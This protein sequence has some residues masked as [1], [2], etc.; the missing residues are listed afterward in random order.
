MLL[1]FLIPLAYGESPLFVQDRS[2][3]NGVKFKI[4]KITS[5]LS[6][7]KRSSLLLFIRNTRI[8]ELPQLVNILKGNM[9]FVGPRPLLPEYD[10]VIRILYPDRFKVLPGLTGLA[11]IKGANKL[12][13]N[14]RLE[15]DIEYAKQQS[16][17]KD[18]LI[19]LKTPFAILYHW[20]NAN[21]VSLLDDPE[22]NQ[23]LRNEQPN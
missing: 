15:L 2:G 20:G 1:A 6:T 16:F 14:K 3:F 13:W 12:P 19:L 8:D 21:S 10:E 18:L 4:Y 22:V 11:Q 5:I 7:G 9:S 17:T 23:K